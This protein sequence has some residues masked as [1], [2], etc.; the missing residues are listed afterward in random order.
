MYKEG[1]AVPQDD[2]LAVQWYRKAAEQGNASGQNN[3]GWMYKEGRGVPQDDQLAVQWYRKAAEQGNASGQNNLIWMYKEGRGVPKNY[4]YA[5]MW[6]NIAAFGGAFEQRPLNA[7][8]KILEKEMTPS[9]IQKAK[10]LARACERKQYKDCE[11]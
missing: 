4:V 1:R 6:M 10:E 7:L 11:V 3:L 8:Q 9:Q 2:Q 5:Y